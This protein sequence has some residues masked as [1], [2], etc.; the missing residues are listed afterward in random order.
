MKNEKLNYLLLTLGGWS[1][2]LVGTVHNAAALFIFEKGA[3]LTGD[4]LYMFLGTGTALMV[5]GIIIIFSVKQYRSGQTTYRTVI[6][7]CAV[8]TIMSGFSVFIFMP[9][10]HNPFAYL[11]QVTSLVL[12]YPALRLKTTGTGGNA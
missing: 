9:G 10:F 5:M 6:L 2:L 7:I 8:Y 3:P 12:F 4:Y 1:T 11:L